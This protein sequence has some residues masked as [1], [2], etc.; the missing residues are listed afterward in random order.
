MTV[1]YGSEGNRRSGIVRHTLCGI[2]VY[3]LGGLR[4]GDK[5][6]AYNPCYGALEIVGLLLLLLILYGV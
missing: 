6:P 3:G 4:E 5:H 1:I 2:L